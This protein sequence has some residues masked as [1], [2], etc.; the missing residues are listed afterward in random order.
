MENKQTLKIKLKEDDKIVQVQPHGL[1]YVDED[2]YAKTMNED[3]KNDNFLTYAVEV[4]GMRADW[5]LNED[6]GL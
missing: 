3:K 4:Y 5:L 2:Y 1:S 6:L